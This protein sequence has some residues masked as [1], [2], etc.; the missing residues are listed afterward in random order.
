MKGLFATTIRLFNYQDS[1]T[2]RLLAQLPEI[3]VKPKEHASME[4]GEE[5]LIKSN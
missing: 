5:N 2:M 1:S 3:N 4:H